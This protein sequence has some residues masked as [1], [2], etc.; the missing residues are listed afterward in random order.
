MSSKINNRILEHDFTIEEIKEKHLQRVTHA[1]D[2]YFKERSTLDT[3]LNTE[4]QMKR[5]LLPHTY[6]SF[7]KQMRSISPSVLKAQAGGI[8]VR[9]IVPPAEKHEPE[10]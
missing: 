6:E 1:L 5:R 8:A 10:L 4:Q 7:K 3:V 9:N 2:P